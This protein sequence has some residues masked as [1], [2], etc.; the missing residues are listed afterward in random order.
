MKISVMCMLLGHASASAMLGS[1]LSAGTGMLPPELRGIAG[2]AANMALAKQ[3]KEKGVI[4]FIMDGSDYPW[5][6]LC[7]TK[8]QI[9]AVK[10]S[11]GMVIAPDKCAEDQSMGCRNPQVSMD[12]A[13]LAQ[14][15]AKTTTKKF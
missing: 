5:I 14:P 9:A 7:P 10:S 12:S 6:C 2:T 13:P 3:N 8:A 1:V 11:S 4:E 15:V